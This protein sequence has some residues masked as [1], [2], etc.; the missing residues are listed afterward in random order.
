MLKTIFA[1][2]AV[3]LIVACTET[4][5]KPE[6]I[7][8]NFDIDNISWVEGKTEFS[9]ALYDN[10]GELIEDPDR[11]QFNKEYEIVI[12]G[13]R[14]VAVYMNKNFGFEFKDKQED[15]MTIEDTHRFQILKTESGLNQVI[16]EMFPVYYMDGKLTHERPQLF[17]FPKHKQA[18]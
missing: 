6:V 18:N 10:N 5:E 16:F 14:P 3:S 9:V 8:M 7:P 13:D 17:V 11:V 4:E 12:T 1:L 15:E 2:M